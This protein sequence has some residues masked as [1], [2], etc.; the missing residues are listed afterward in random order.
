LSK[1]ENDQELH[2]NI[3]V[4]KSRLNSPDLNRIENIIKSKPPSPARLGKL[5]LSMNFAPKGTQSNSFR[6]K[7]KLRKYD[8]ILGQKFYIQRFRYNFTKSVLPSFSD[9][10]S[11]VPKI[12]A[13]ITTSDSF[14][15]KIP[16]HKA[17]SMS[18][19]AK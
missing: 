10:S 13:Q 6:N 16:D 2:T 17:N 1:Y 11:V 5:N 15:N 4:L 12:N 9:S 7:I 8:K 3:R 19:F 18:S 14:E